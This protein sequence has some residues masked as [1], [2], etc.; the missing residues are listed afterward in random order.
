MSWRCSSAHQGPQ[1]VTLSV[2]FPSEPQ[3]ALEHSL[4]M[5]HASSAGFERRVARLFSETIQRFESLDAGARGIGVVID[6]PKIR[7][8]LG[9]IQNLRHEIPIVLCQQKADEL[10]CWLMFLDEH[11][12]S[13]RGPR[14]DAPPPSPSSLAELRR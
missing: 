9:T 8:H 3:Y 4:S 13:Q 5:V 14:R 6:S 10:L 12:M 2:H 7:S 1:N 11:I